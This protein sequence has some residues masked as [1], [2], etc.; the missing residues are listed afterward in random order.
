MVAREGRDRLMRK[1]DSAPWCGRGVGV[2]G[3]RNHYGKAGPSGPP[4]PRGP[5]WLF[6]C[7]GLGMLP[8]MVRS[9]KLLSG[10]LLAGLV[11]AG[12]WFVCRATGC[13]ALPEGW[14]GVAPATRASDPFAGAW[15]GTGRSSS[16][17]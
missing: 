16:K 4:F 6:E 1:F 13:G 8:R 12:A 5:A 14:R 17:P 9:R 2:R 11:V 10:L 3:F 7:R 15:E